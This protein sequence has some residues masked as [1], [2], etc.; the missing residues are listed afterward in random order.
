VT[1][2]VVVLLVVMVFGLVRQ[3]AELHVAVRS[4]TSVASPPAVPST[5]FAPGGELPDLRGF[6]PVPRPTLFLFL[7]SSC[8]PCQDL[9]SD[10]QAADR[11]WSKRLSLGELETVLVTDPQGAT[12]YG[13]LAVDQVLLQHDGDIAK[14]LGVS[15]TPYGVAADARGILRAG[16]VVNSLRDMQT[17]VHAAQASLPQE[18]LLVESG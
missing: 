8:G 2:A 5:E 4:L 12:K 13:E 7:S 18:R 10:L 1:W 15:V 9:A 16:R 6:T 17:L 14:A 11:D 3:L